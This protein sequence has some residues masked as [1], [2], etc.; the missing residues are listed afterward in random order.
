MSQVPLL[1]AEFK[2]YDFKNSGWILDK[3]FSEKT[4]RNPVHIN[5]VLFTRYLSTDK[6]F[7]AVTWSI[8]SGRYD[9]KIA[10]GKTETISG[11]VSQIVD[12]IDDIKFLKSQSTSK[13]S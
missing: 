2:S 5:G 9:G 3:S 6:E 4:Y 7:S 12:A 1:K 8:Y 10:G 11:S 13:G